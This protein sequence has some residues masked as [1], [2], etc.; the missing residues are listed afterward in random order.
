[1]FSNVIDDYDGG[2]TAGSGNI[3]AFNKQIRADSLE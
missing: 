1:M 3:E 2:V